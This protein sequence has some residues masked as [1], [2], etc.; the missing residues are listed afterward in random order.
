[1]IEVQNSTPLL[2]GWYDPL[3]QDVAGLRTTEIKGL[4]R[5]WARTFIAGALYDL[6]LLRGEESSNTVLKPSEDSITTI[7]YFVGKILGLGY[8]GRIDKKEE[9][10]ASRFTLY[11]EGR[12]KPKQLS[13]K[14]QRIRLLGIKEKKKGVKEERWIEGVEE[15]QKFRIFVKKRI[16]KDPEAEGLALKI[17][18]LALQLSGIGKGSRRGLGSLDICSLDACSELPFTK[19]IKSLIDDVYSSCCEIVKKYRNDVK[20]SSAIRESK[21]SDFPPLPLI[22]KGSI[23]N[24]KISQIIRVRNIKFEALHNFFVRSERCRVLYGDPRCYDDIR[25]E[26]VAWFLGLPRQQK[27]EKNTGYFTEDVPRRA[28]PVI[29]SYHTDKNV[30]GDGG[31]ITILVS[32]DWPKKILWRG[33]GMKRPI[34]INCE[35]IVNALNIVFNEFD[36]YLRKLKAV[37]EVIWP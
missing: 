25:C 28:S 18:L 19:D 26:R 22:S 3:K 7:S 10:E 32:G 6:G 1:V 11:V 29:V 31:F 35:S 20:T 8:V 21:C 33:E 9:S 15:G 16:S 34:N 36:Q 12:V 30:F 37:T 4:W 17:L 13:S 5:W 23:Y 14:L 24:V 27:N 2:V